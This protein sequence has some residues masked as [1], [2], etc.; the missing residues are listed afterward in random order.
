MSYVN[1]FTRSRWDI[2]AMYKYG[3][4][5]RSGRGFSALKCPRHVE[6]DVDE[7]EVVS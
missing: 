4:A 3:V 1:A 6:A 7:I 2:V 5:S